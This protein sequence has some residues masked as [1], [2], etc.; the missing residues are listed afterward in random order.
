[1]ADRTHEPDA[2]PLSL[3]MVIEAYFPST[4]GAERQLELIAGAL[5]D[6]GHDVL[7][8][9]PRL[10]RR[11]PAGADQHGRL[12]LW[13]IGF[14]AVPLLGGL[15]LQ[16]RLAWLLWRDRHRYAAIHVHVAHHMGAVCA[17]MGRLLGKP[18]VVKFSGWWEMEKGCLRRDGGLLAWLS[19]ALLRRAT[20]L[21]AISSRIAS[22]LAAFGFRASRIHRIP[23][24]VATARFEAL[25]RP[26]A[27]AQPPRMVFVGRLVPEKCLD[28][29]LRAWRLADLGTLGWRLRIV[30][31]GPQEQELRALAREQGVD[32]CVEWVG[33]SRKV[34][35]HLA[36][37][38]VGVLVSR[39]EGLSNTLLEYFAAG[40]P[41]VATRV[42]GSEDFVVHGS[43][44]WLSAAGD[45][46]ALAANLAA[47][48]ATDAATRTRMGLQARDDVARQAGLASVLAQL[49][50]LYR[51]PRP[52]GD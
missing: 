30:G 13:R 12:R 16:L 49:E 8:V 24:A 36:V 2:G 6:R 50:V 11:F 44:G 26:R 22:D 33:E 15:V 43:N 27:D 45:C 1:M 32:G 21:Q 48:A 40:L 51:A 20:A 38:D 18:V 25:P 4:G 42:S 10:D 41:V 31:G 23:N 9:A 28:L 19:R 46:A 17:V 39:A 3:L 35:E 47:C 29:L 7:V 37:A 14:P 34:E 5:V 52:V